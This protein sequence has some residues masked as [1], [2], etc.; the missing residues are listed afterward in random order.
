MKERFFSDLKNLG[1]VPGD[2]VMVH[3]SYRS[4]GPI[5]GGAATFFEWL[6][7]YLGEEGTIVFPAFSY[8]FVNKN[9][10]VFN[11][12]TT[13]TCV[14]YLPAYFRTEVDGVLRSM[15]P[16]HSCTARGRLAEYLT[17]D[18]ELDLTPVGEHSPLRK[19]TEI[20]G[21]ILYIGCTVAPTTLMHGVEEMVEPVY[22]YHP[23]PIDYVLED[24]E[25]RV[26]NQHAKRHNFIVDGVLYQQR[27]VRLTEVLQ[28][29]EIH[30]GQLLEADTWCLSAEAIWRRGLEIL[31]RDPLAFVEP[32]K[33]EN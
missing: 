22:L 26:I 10:P 23:E 2:T 7:E 20:G 19:L 9:N 14:G 4:L 25:G 8:S 24:G 29:D 18:H 28:G 31:K 21:K 27:Y 33:L 12:L 32:K 17:A 6:I 15:H 3:S 1:I 16:T 30:H 11:R 13:P 5:E